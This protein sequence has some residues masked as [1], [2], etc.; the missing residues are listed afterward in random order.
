MWIVAQL[1]PV[2]DDKV[3]DGLIEVIPKGEESIVVHEGDIRSFS[4]PDYL[5]GV[6]NLSEAPSGSH[7]IRVTVQIKDC[8]PVEDTVEVTVNLAPTADIALVDCESVPEGTLVTFEAVDLNDPEGDAVNEFLWEFG[9]GTSEELINDDPTVTHLYDGEVTEPVVKLMCYDK[10]GA[11]IY[12]GR[13][14]LLAKCQPVVTHD[15]GCD[16]MWF[17][18]VAG[19]DTFTYCYRGAT[20]PRL[21]TALGCAAV[22]ARDGCPGGTI[23]FT[24]PLGPRLPPAA[25]AGIFAWTF[26]IEANLNPRTND[27][28]RCIEGQIARATMSRGALGAPGVIPL[29]DTQAKPDS[30]SPLPDEPVGG[31]TVGNARDKYP[32]F[33]GPG[34][35]RDGYDKELRFSKRHKATKI[36]WWDPPRLPVRAG[37]QHAIHRAEFVAFVKGTGGA[38]DTCWCWIRIEHQWKRPPNGGH[39]DL[40][41]GPP[42]I[43][44]TKVM[45]HNCSP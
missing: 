41:G 26:E 25:G 10:R 23:P 9:D 37:D 15:C 43:R 30:P 36:Q 5:L 44:M 14:V 1:D 21:L 19:I 13:D 3:V 16:D 20:L 33:G 29:P 12:V 4:A 17:Y 6:W 38:F 11:T 2:V 40:P 32:A 28:K 45:G 39:Q 18:S 35:G 22:T 24:C 42:P 27:S 7:T 34:W 8:P 31:F